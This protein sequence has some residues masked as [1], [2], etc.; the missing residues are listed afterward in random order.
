MDKKKLYALIAVLVVV[1]G[2][3]AWYFMYYTKTPTYSLN[4]IRESFQTHDV[5]TFRQH[6]D[7]DR[8]LS[9]LVDDYMDVE[10]KDSPELKDNPFKGLA[11]GFVTMMKPTVVTS[12]KDRVIRLVE[13]GPT[14]DG[15]QKPQA[16]G[17]SAD[18]NIAKVENDINANTLQFHGIVYEKK[19]GKVATVGIKATDAQLFDDFT[20]DIKMNE[21]NDGKWQFVEVA[22]AKEYF[23]RLANDKKIAIKKYINAI[24]P[25]LED[26]NNKRKAMVEKYGG[27]TKLVDLT[28]PYIEEI[29][30][31]HNDCYD[32]VEKIEVPVAAQELANIRKERRKLFEEESVI[33]KKIANGDH[34]QAVFEEYQ[35]WRKRLEENWNKIKKIE[36]SVK[37]VQIP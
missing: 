21:L 28:L 11:E 30:K 13:N 22:N 17:N 20:F 3:M 5:Q 36:E 9:R 34:S 25:I 23:I 32:A 7:L 37:D 19:D 2:G 33:M 26:A 16:A 14:E 35:N 18:K 8:A 6:V 1:C 24:Q 31:S 27:S 10:M 12:L 15:Q 4:L 29:A